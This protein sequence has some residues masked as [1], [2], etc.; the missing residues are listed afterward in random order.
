M[1]SLPLSLLEERLKRLN[2]W[3]I[4]GNFL[5]ARY[6]FKDL[7][8]LMIFLNE[9]M[10]FASEKDYFPYSVE[11]KKLELVIRLASPENYISEADL[12]LAELAEQLKK[13]TEA[14]FNFLE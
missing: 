8:D 7:S 9:F 14:G 1:S 3:K 10:E 4:E 2:D 13:K 6:H 12:Y 5:V 11:I